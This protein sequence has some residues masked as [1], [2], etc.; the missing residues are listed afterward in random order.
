[1]DRVVLFFM[2]LLSRLPLRVHYAFSSFLA[3]LLQKVLHYRVQTVNINIARS[4]PELNYKEIR[5]VVDDFY[6]HLADTVVESVWMLT[7]STEA[8]GRQV[9]ITG[10][11]ALNRA[12]DLNR[13][14]VIMVG[15]LGNWEIF[16]G[17]PDLRSHYGINID[18]KDFLYV[19]KRPKSR[20]ADKVITRI[21]TRHGSCSII[22]SHQI[23]RHIVRH[24]EGR[25]A[26]FFICDQNPPHCMSRFT[27]D[28]LNQKTYM[29]EGPETVAA[30]M[31]MPVL[32]C[33]LIRHG[34]KDNEAHFELIAEN[35]AECPEGFITER[36]ARLLEAD[37]IE[38][39]STWLWS[40]KRWK[41]RIS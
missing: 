4:F 23:I 14:A 3:W 17:L 32:Y 41:K 15:H 21:R 25:Q 38:H 1:M 27:A 11:D 20:L 8:V 40:H 33:G 13:N 31:G 29:I 26:F 39:K 24:R 18:N 30:K 22:E 2:T 35:A 34:R 9:R 36:F 10:Q 5:E 28:F 19:Y 37:I 16:T 7:A 12:L 6:H